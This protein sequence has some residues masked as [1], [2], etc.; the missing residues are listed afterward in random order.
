[1]SPA[2]AF[3]WGPIT[4]EPPC[5]WPLHK[6]SALFYLWATLA[7][8]GKL[9]KWF[10]FWDTCRISQHA[11]RSCDQAL[12]PVILGDTHWYACRIHCQASWT[13]VWSDRP[14]HKGVHSSR[15]QA[16]K[17]T[18]QSHPPAHSQKLWLN[19]NWRAPVANTGDTP[20]AHGSGGLGE[21]CH[22]APWDTVYKAT[23]SRSRDIAYKLNT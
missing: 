8:P 12:H 19:H 4:V 13:T 11:L 15:C 7:S 21:L 1:M 18:I 9:L 17:T 20:G 23:L 6:A 10:L 3:P 22:S 2:T 14:T 16:F 5:S